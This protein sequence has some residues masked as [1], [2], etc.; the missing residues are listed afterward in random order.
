MNAYT[1]ISSLILSSLKYVI[2]LYFD[3][4]YDFTKYQY[5]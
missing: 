5:F 4:N 2:F 1:C 3:E